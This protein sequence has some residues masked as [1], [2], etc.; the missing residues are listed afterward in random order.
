MAKDKKRN[1]IPAIR[2]EQWMK[3]WDKIPPSQKIER[4]F[5]AFSMNV[6]DL[7]RLSAGH[8]RSAQERESASQDDNIQRSLDIGRS[9]KIAQYVQ[10]G[11]PMDTGT[12]AQQKNRKYDL[13]NPG[14]LPAI[15]VNILKCENSTISS[16]D[17]VEI[18]DKGDLGIKIKLPSGF[19]KNWRPENEKPHPIEVIDGQHRLAAFDETASGDKYKKYELPVIAFHGLSRERQAYLFYTINMRPKRI[20]ASLAY[21]LYPLLRQA[22]WL[23]SGPD[24]HKVP[25][26]RE[27]RSR[28]IIDLLWGHPKSP[29]F[30]R[31]NMLGESLGQEAGTQVSQAAW[32]RSLYSTFMK[33]ST[34]KIGGLYYAKNQNHANESTGSWAWLISQQVTLLITMGSMLQRHLKR[35]LNDSEFFNSKF[36]L[37]NH[38]VGMRGLLNLWNDML[39][40]WASESTSNAKKF[41][42]DFN[43]PPPTVQQ[44]EHSEEHRKFHKE[45]DLCLQK[46]MVRGSE[47]KNAA[48]VFM[49]N[50]SKHLSSY[51]WQTFKHEKVQQLPADSLIRIQKQAL[52]GSAGYKI[53]RDELIL[54][55]QVQC[56]NA[57]ISN[58]AS[59]LYEKYGIKP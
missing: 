49:D 56:S 57:E 7:K 54:H 45:I 32:V 36:C 53:I 5:Y 10:Y 29:W 3:A 15:I 6:L 34:S 13:R 21:D 35:H 52:R 30:H 28:E 33:G 25:A 19:D 18:E 40:T 2:I 17:A 23:E 43:L 31:I 58:I 11:Y 20:N 4:H 59:I 48:L 39:F 16:K 41:L 47:D 14:W 46:I 55:L 37:L 26:Y 38:D 24:A 8:K 12:P 22:T 27:I 42:D 44:E 9:K 1:T 51:N 50:L